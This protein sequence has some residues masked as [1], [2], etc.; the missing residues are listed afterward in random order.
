MLPPFELNRLIENNFLLC[1]HI[2]IVYKLNGLQNSGDKI[3]FL[4][5]IYKLLENY[6]TE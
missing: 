2:Y 3:T 4:Q 1:L 6:K 5:N